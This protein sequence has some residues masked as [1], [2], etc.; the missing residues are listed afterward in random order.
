MVAGTRRGGGGRET[1]LGAVAVLGD[2]RALRRGTAVDGAGVIHEGGR[3]HA[4]VG[5]GEG[6]VR[7]GHDGELPRRPSIGGTAGGGES[8][9]V[10][11]TRG[12]ARNRV[13]AEQC[14]LCSSRPGAAP[15]SYNPNRRVRGAL[16]RGGGEMGRRHRAWLPGGGVAQSGRSQA[17]EAAGRARVGTLPGGGGG[18]KHHLSAL[19]SGDPRP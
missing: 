1:R 11:G 6:P 14:W 8:R 12:Q 18:A 19:L 16:P 10:Q 17:C 13:R 9:V 5:P 15:A 3:C 2:T 7:R 4:G